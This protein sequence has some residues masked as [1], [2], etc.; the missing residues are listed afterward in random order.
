M[1]LVAL[2][3]RS[4]QVLWDVPTGDY[5]TGEG[6][7]HPPLIADGK[8]FIG[9]AGGD[10]AARGKFQ[11]RDAQTGALVWEL[12]TVPRKGEPGFDTWT[13]NEHWPPLGGAAWN[14]VSYDRELKLVYFSTGQPTP[15]S[16]ASR[17]PGDSLYT[18]S[19]LAVEADTGEIRWHYQ[20]VPA[21]EWDRAA[22]E[23]MLVDLEID[24]VLRKALVQTGKIG[25]GVVLDRQT[26]EFLRAF[27]TAYDN[28]ITGWTDEG[29]PI[30]DPQRLP[31]PEDVDSAKVFEICPH[32]HGA[33]NLQAPSYSP[34]TGY[35]YLGVN[36]SCMNAQVV[37]P[38]FRPGSG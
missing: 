37:T 19:V 9:A 27:R 7:A 21:D 14:T 18:N 6:H 22:Y 29:R 4:G 38:V 32:L 34:I 17:G 2:D 25:W 8:V 36:N 10:L 33:R 13:P 1:H 30:Y 31:K 3:A 23:S 5:K 24:G 20:L 11:A 35:Y 28:M 15:W 26:G 16:T 12:Y